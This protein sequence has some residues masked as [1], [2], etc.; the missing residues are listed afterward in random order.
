MRHAGATRSSS[1]YTVGFSVPMV[2]LALWHDQQI[3]T[4]LVEDARGAEVRAR[5]DASAEWCS[6]ANCIPRT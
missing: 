4:R 6:T 3:N 2:A 1:L 5:R